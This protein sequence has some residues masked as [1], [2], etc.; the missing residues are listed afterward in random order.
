M[1]R[2]LVTGGCG[3]LG[4]HL[5]DKLV[6][7]NHTITVIDNLSNG[8]ISN[9]NDSIKKIKLIKAD[10]SKNG[11]WKKYFKKIDVVIHL[12]AIADIVP[13]INNPT[14]YFNVNVKGTLNI[15]ENCREFKV[16][17]LY[18]L[19]HHHLTGFL[20][21]YPTDEFEKLNPEYPY[22]LTKKIGE[23]IVMSWGK[24]YNLNVTSL[25]FFNIYGERSR[26]S[27]S[28]GAM[29]GI[30]LAQKLNKRPFTIV[31]DG[32]QKRDFTYVTDVVDAIIKSIK[33]KKKNQII[34]I[35]SGKCYS[36]NYI[37]KLLGGKKIYIPK[38][39]GE[40]EITWAK[41]Q[42]AKRLLNWKPKIG[43]EQGVNKL[44][45][46]INLWKNAPIWD[47]KKIKIATADWFKYLK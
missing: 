42:K 4:S 13:S 36:V 3:F 5:V 40:P 22:A 29:F 45:D 1:A 27:G 26:T 8:K 46:N 15:L 20:K 23:D 14:K 18:M 44:L 37:A 28:Y 35:G 10:I 6:N 2:I 11:Q 38:R 24:I 30:F 16:K 47:K 9:L 17:K 39:P 34:N 12:A 19:H 41:I 32:N 21:K 33:L 7:L 25:R 43:I 31:G